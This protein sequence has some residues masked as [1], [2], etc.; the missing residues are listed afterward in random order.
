MRV[1]RSAVKLSVFLVLT[2][3]LG[4][5]V[6]STLVGGSVGTTDTYHAIFTDV[7]GLHTGDSV[8]VSGVVVGSVTGETLVDATHV[9]VTFTANRDQQLTTTTDAVVRYANLLGQRFLA[10]TQDDPPGSPLRPGGTIPQSRTAPALSLTALF[11]GFRPLF[12]SLQPSQINQLA[13]E[14]VE[15]LQGEGGTVADLFAQTAQFTTDI[16]KRDDLIKGVV[17]GLTAVLHTVST[18]D[19][20]LQSAIGSL[21]SLTGALSADSPAIG[22]ALTGVDQLIGSVSDLLGGLDQHNLHGDAVDLQQLAGVIAQNSSAL[23]A[24]VKEFPQAFG[25]FDVVT[26]SGNWINAYPCAINAAVRGTPSASPTQIAAL[27]ADYLGGGKNVLST[28]VAVL[29]GLLP[30]G[31]VPVRLD[32]PTGPVGDPNTHSQVCR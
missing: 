23:D 27:I 24:V 1:R 25:A 10:L 20:Q 11:N 8:R 6:V 17:D 9:R 15:V 22:D 29:G 31:G 16:G 21:K 7:S 30:K 4:V 2:T 28:V 32:I 19:T 13:G 14:I 5:M 26:Q 18:H 12:Q 3:L